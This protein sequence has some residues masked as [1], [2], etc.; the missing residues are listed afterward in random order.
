M[1]FWGIVQLGLHGLPVLFAA[2]IWR[3]YLEHRRKAQHQALEVLKAINQSNEPLELGRRAIAGVIRARSEQPPIEGWVE[4]RQVVNSWIEAE[5]RLRAR[6]F[7]LVVE[8]LNE[9]VRVDLQRGT[10]WTLESSSVS[11][12]ATGHVRELIEVR[13]GERV[14]VEGT[15]Q[16][17]KQKGGEGYRGGKPTGWTLREDAQPILIRAESAARAHMQARWWPLGALVFAAIC[18]LASVINLALLVVSESTSTELP[19]VATIREVT[20]KGKGNKTYIVRVLDIHYTDVRGAAQTCTDL[21]ARDG[22]VTGQ[23]VEVRA[24]SLLP[25]AC[26]EAGRFRSSWSRLI[27]SFVLTI[28]LFGFVGAEVLSRKEGYRMGKPWFER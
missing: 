28:I 17:R 4:Y 24:S 16:S 3:F 11:E 18:I 8:D 10:Q 7:D 5:R 19:G 21:P 20:K 14:S 6:S 23:P 12:T 27:V 25:G 2:V 26:Y 13:D 9:V 1:D 15:L 22:V